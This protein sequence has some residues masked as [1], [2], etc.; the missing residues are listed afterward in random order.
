ML[1]TILKKL[2]SLIW[3]VLLILVSGYLAITIIVTKNYY[4]QVYID[5]PE[6]IAE[7]INLIKE[8]NLE[9]DEI[10]EM[11]MSA[12]VGNWYTNQYNK[13]WLLDSLISLGFQPDTSKLCAMQQYRL[14]HPLPIQTKPEIIE[15]WSPILRINCGGEG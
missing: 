3:I 13:P 6:G 8:D 5:I 12:M 4:Q 10:T 1:Q 9:V 7:Q 2:A 11:F 14:A 15:I